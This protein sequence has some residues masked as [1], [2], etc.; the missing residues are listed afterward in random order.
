MSGESWAMLVGAIAAAVL[1]VAAWAWWRV[2]RALRER[3]GSEERRRF[4]RYYR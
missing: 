1:G 3:R 4:G 2:S